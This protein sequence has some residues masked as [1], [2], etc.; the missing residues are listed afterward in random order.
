M[1]TYNPAYRKILPAIPAEFDLTLSLKLDM[2]PVFPFQ[3]QK[4]L[5]VSAGVLQVSAGVLQV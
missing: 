1:R 5:Q 2:T 4:F 3:V